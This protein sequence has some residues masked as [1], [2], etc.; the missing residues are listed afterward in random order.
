MASFMSGSSARPYLAP[1]CGKHELNRTP[2][3]IAFL[4][5][6]GFG[7]AAEGRAMTSGLSA[8]AVLE[9]IRGEAASGGGSVSPQDLIYVQSYQPGKKKAR[10][11][12]KMIPPS[13][14]LQAAL[15]YAPG[16]KGLGVRLLQG[17]RLMYAVKLKTGDRIRRVLIDAR[18]G[19]VLGE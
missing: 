10:S 5:V 7:V 13:A 8:Y 6:L 15:R 1:L 9:P 2:V 11:G 18:T 19:Q 16:S 12:N 14:A 4:L 17:P 3:H